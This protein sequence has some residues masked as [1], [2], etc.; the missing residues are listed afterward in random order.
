MTDYIFLKALRAIK[1]PKAQTQWVFTI[2]GSGS[3]CYYDQLPTH[4]YLPDILKL[5]FIRFPVGT[6][7]LW[8]NGYIYHIQPGDYE[9]CVTYN[10]L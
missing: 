4:I 2:Y 7:K 10:Y 1:A 5:Y 8:N 3:I 9:S 6:K